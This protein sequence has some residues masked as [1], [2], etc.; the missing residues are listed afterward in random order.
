MVSSQMSNPGYSFKAGKFNFWKM[1]YEPGGIVWV[2]KKG[3]D[4]PENREKFILW[5]VNT[6][7]YANPDSF[8]FLNDCFLNDED[9]GGCIDA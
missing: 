8:V 2:G 7:P 6:N 1:Q 5:V 4:T 9:Y 3:G